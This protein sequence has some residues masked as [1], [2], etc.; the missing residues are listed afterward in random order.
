MGCP[1]IV[2][3]ALIVLGASLLG[4]SIYPTSRIIRELPPGPVHLQWRILRGF[5]AFFIAGYLAYLFVFAAEKTTSH[6]L[7]SGI[8]FFGACFVLLVCLLAL[9]TV[10]DVKRISQLETENITDPLMEIYN[11]RYLERRLEDEFTRARRYGNPFSLLLLDI[12]RFKEVNDTYG[13]PTGDLVLKGIG[14]LLKENIRTVDVPARYGGE[15]AVVLL[16]H[17]ELEGA[18]ILAERIRETVEAHLFPADASF[19][20]GATLRCTISIGT[21]ALTRECPDAIRLLQQADAALYRAKQGGR[22]RTVA[23]RHE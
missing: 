5:I 16:P 17:T 22:N 21:A 8:F 10:R 19:R 4:Y 3:N 18:E 20:P 6:L 12:D 7:V 9:G 13:H 2:S 14:A 15:E 23:Y 11:R 1:V